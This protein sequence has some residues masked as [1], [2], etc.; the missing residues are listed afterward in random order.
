MGTRL[1]LQTLLETKLGTRNVYFQP[2]ESVK[3]NYP[4]FVYFLNDI[5]T[6]KADDITYKSIRKYSVSYISKDP[7]NTMVDNMLTLPYC[8]FNRRY[9]AD[10]LY[11]DV[12]DLYY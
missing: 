9:I 3:I 4:A 1:Q 8:S 12:F 5:A 10:N 6:R 2:G 11:H 7:D